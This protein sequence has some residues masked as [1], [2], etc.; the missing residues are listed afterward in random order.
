LDRARH[1]LGAC[2]GAYAGLSLM[3]RILA[4]TS[5]IDANQLAWKGW[6]I[7]AFV[8]AAMMAGV[9]LRSAFGLRLRLRRSKPADVITTA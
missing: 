8:L 1:V 7:V 3:L 9:A 2:M 4:S 6:G 5:D